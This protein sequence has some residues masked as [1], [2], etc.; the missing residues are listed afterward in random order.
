MQV[1]SNREATDRD[2]REFKGRHEAEQSAQRSKRLC[3]V[4]RVSKRIQQRDVRRNAVARLRIVKVAQIAEQGFSLGDGQ[5]DPRSK[6]HTS[7]RS[8]R[9]RDTPYPSGRPVFRSLVNDLNEE[10]H[11]HAAH[12]AIRPW[13][14]RGGHEGLI[15][16]GD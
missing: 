10:M 5:D 4:R 1:R 7:R 15:P 9:F 6:R 11:G 12:A 8:V 2:E 3:N 14:S 16:D 13:I